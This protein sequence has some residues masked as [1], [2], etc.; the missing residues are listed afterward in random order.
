MTALAAERSTPEMAVSAAVHPMRNLP[1]TASV[2]IWKGALVVIDSGGDAKPGVTA[3]GL[4]AAGRAEQTVDNSSGGAG[5]QTV[6]VKPGVFKY[7]NLGTDLVAQA[8]V[9]TD[10]Y[11]TDDQTVSATSATNTK[12]VAGRVIQVDTDGVWVAVGLAAIY[13]T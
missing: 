7:G 6:N 4:T 8:N 5:A 13:G 3:T 9:G 12:S 2:K 11:V 1:M 10:C